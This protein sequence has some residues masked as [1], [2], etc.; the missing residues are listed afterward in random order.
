MVAIIVTESVF[1]AED[2]F[3]D[4]MAKRGHFKTSKLSKLRRQRYC[5]HGCGQL[6]LSTF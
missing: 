5:S 2:A 1:S 3:L 6:G 4:E